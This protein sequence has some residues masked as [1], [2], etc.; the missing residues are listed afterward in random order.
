MAVPFDLHRVRLESDSLF[1]VIQQRNLEYLLALDST[2][3]TCLYTRC[4]I[5][6]QLFYIAVS[7]G[8]FVL[9]CCKLFCSLPALP[10]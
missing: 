5:L 1:G 8:T 6:V 4:L 9:L 3:L 2:R 10:T 7:T